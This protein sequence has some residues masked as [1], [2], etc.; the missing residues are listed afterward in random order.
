MEPLISI[1][2]PVYRVEDYLSICIDSILAQ[3][4]RNLEL[5]LVD[6]KS[7]DNCSIICDEYAKRDTRVIVIH[8]EK[9][10][11]AASARNAGLDASHG[12]YIMFVDGDDHII[13]QAC[14]IMLEK[15]VERDGDMCMT[16]LWTE[17]EL[18]GICVH[19]ST[20]RL[21]DTV[22]CREEAFARISGNE[23][24]NFLVVWGKLY[25]R[26][27]FDDLRFEDG[28][29]YE[30]V[31]IMHRIF[32]ACTKIVTICTPT[33]FYLDRSDSIMKSAYRI[34]R[35]NDEASAY[36]DRYIYFIRLGYKQYAKK[37]IYLCCDAL[38]RGLR[39]LPVKGN[40]D[41]FF[42]HLR[43]VLM[44]FFDLRSIRLLCLFIQNIFKK[45]PK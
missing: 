41:I 17:T 37:A 13:P 24:L 42:P 27:I 14:Q 21:S 15:L 19:A 25:K 6:D 44:N 34:D 1:I 45:W 9:N 36:W 4:H 43:N 35:M 12:D 3:T 10:Q 29:G 20:L 32:G 33:Y 18:R 16:G 38:T 26:S 5:I 11:G 23:N 7:P 30:D 22:I 8:Q 28:R 31:F 2:V 40:E 39:T